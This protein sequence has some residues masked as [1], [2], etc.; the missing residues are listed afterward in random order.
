M[1]SEN[2]RFYISMFSQFKNKLTVLKNYLFIE[3]YL[4]FIFFHLVLLVGG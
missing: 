4:I 3:V 2:G 1:D